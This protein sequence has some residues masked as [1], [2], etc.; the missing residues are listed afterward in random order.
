MW[1]G[2]GFVAAAA[3]ALLIAKS[4]VAGGFALAGILLLIRTLWLLKK[5]RT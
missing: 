5:S 1:A 4:W 3:L 2:V